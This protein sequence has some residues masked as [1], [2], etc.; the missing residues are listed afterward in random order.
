MSEKKYRQEIKQLLSPIQTILLNQRIRAVMAADE[1]SGANESYAIRSVYFDT[2]DDRAYEEKEV[3]ISEREKI[4]I[5]IYNFSDSVIRLER[6]EKRE[7]LIYKESVPLKKDTAEALLHGEYAPLA[8]CHTPLTDYVY[9]LTR[10]AALHPVVTVD[11]V[12]KAYVYPVGDVRITFD[13]ALQAGKPDIPF[14][15]AG[16]VSDVLCGQTI[17][18]IKFNQYLPEHIRQVLSSVTGETMA[19]SKYTLCRQN[20]LQKQGD[21]LGGKL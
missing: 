1:H 19:L 11:Y 5:R 14:F 12:R 15:Q 6:K 7:T 3:G 18:E 20:L 13:T 16:N 2:F 10:S 4:R 9:G 17:L 8:D 21:Y